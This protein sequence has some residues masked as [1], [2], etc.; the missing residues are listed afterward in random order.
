[1]KVI[2]T[3]DVPRVGKKGDLLTVADGYGRN[4]LI[5][6]GV[7]VEATAGKLKDYQFQKKNQE[8]KTAKLRAKAEEK[9]SEIE[10]KI[11]TLPTSCGDTGKLFGA[12]TTTQI[13]EA[14]QKQYKLTIDKKDIKVEE[15]IKLLGQYPVKLKLFQGVEAKMTLSV[16]KA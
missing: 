16:E 7:A 6:C 13:A 3:T 11:V 9:K 14:L 8:D 15:T 4:F 2:L 1:M 12:V 5:G 10:G